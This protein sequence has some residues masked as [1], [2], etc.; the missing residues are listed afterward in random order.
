MPRN[1]RN[2]WIELSVDGRTS[3]IAAGPVRKDGGFELRILQRSR[4]DIVE[5]VDCW[6]RV[7]DDGTI[8]LHMRPSSRCTAKVTHDAVDGQTTIESQR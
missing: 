4:G 1:V 6:G 3:R 8:K 7:D 2:F 5:A